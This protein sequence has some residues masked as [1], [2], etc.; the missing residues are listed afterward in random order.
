MERGEQAFAKLFLKQRLLSEC[1][2]E[3]SCVGKNLD[4]SIPEEYKGFKIFRGF[5]TEANEWATDSARK[6]DYRTNFSLTPSDGA[7]RIRNRHESAG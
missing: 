3:S 4:F 1:L 5:V 7:S 2:N 6:G